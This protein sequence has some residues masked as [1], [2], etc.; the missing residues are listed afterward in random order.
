MCVPK[1]YERS[2]V[3]EAN[4]D[5]S[6]TNSGERTLS[7]KRFSFSNSS[8][9]DR[10]NF[11]HTE[12][13]DAEMP[14]P[15]WRIVRVHESAPDIVNQS[16]IVVTF[17][18]SSVSAAG[19]LDDATCVETP[20]SHSLIHDTHWAETLEPVSAGPNTT[21][22]QGSAATD[23][24]PMAFPET[25]ICADV[26][27]DEQASGPSTFWLTLIP[28]LRGERSPQPLYVGPRKTTPTADTF[29]YTDQAGGY[30]IDGS[31]NPVVV[32]GKSQVCATLTVQGTCA[33]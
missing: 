2:V 8:C 31:Y 14:G 11:G 3:L 25:R 17:A 24:M 26:P 30:R 1:E 10:K 21:H 5:Y 16:N 15:G 29:N 33:W 12:A 7:G 19:W 18:D 6:I 9:E 22:K 13:W 23:P 28:Y 32:S 20:F 4:I 27:K